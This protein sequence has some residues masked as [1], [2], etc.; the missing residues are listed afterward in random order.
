MTTGRNVGDNRNALAIA[1][2]GGLGAL[3]ASLLNRRPAAGAQTVEIPQEILTALAVL[4]ENSNL[5][6]QQL[7]DILAALGAVPGG[8]PGVPGS[9]V[10]QN[11]NEIFVFTVFPP[12]AVVPV[13]FPELLVAY[14]KDLVIRALPGNANNVYIG[15]SAGEAANPN[16]SW[17]LQANDI[18]GWKIH[19]TKQL[20]V[21][22]VVVGDGV[23]V[24]AERRP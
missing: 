24:T 12:V 11:P 19:N 23:M 8:I 18:V 20:W 22:A 1:A 16:S 7:N 2:A 5:T 13:Q 14:D 6:A 3:I 15:N 10:L 9:S 4:V 17:L 21:S